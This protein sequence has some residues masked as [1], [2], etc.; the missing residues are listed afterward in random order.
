MTTPPDPASLSHGSSDRSDEQ[1]LI[2]Y[3]THGRGD[4]LRELMYRYHDDLIRF[5]TRFL[6]GDR[7]AAADVFQDTFLQVHVSAGTFD[8]SRRFKPWLFTIAA[9]KARDLLRKTSRR[10]T[11]ELSA[12][13]SRGGD[14]GEGATFV[15][16]MEANI[17]SPDSGL[18]RKELSN[19]VQRALDSLSPILKEVLLLAYFQKLPYAQIADDL[20]IPLGT[21]KSRLHAAVASFA[22]AIGTVSPAHAPRPAGEGGDP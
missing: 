16:L 20:E 21:V 3:R 13:V 14:G 12:P 10:Y 2:E 22:K 6:S 19:V 17:P 15:D 4:D 7:H 9:N 1:L 5:L 18:D 8:S 11:A